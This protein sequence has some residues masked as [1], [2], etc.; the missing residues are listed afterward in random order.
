MEFVSKMVVLLK[1]SGVT[2]FY[3]ELHRMEGIVAG[4]S[5]DWQEQQLKSRDTSPQKDANNKGAPGVIWST[6]F[7]SCPTSKVAS[8]PGEEVNGV[9]KSYWKS[10]EQQSI[11]NHQMRSLYL[12]YVKKR[13][14]GN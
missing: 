13:V 4:A 9:S 14:M 11:L 5:V 6:S 10:T 1:P 8:L 7:V 2:S 3:C 12:L